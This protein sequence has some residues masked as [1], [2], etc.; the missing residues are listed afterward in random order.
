MS[1][2][3]DER[4]LALVHDLRTPLTVVTGSAELLEMRGE[5]LGATERREYTRRL[6]EGARGAAGA[7]GRRA[8]R[9]LHAA[10][11]TVICG[12]SPGTWTGGGS[13]GSACANP[14]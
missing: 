10:R 11:W 13:A 4:L 12:S 6:A 3:P 5:E 8:E 1:A 2:D 14:K 7:P 9:A